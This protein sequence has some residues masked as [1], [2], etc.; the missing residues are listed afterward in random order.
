M[1][2]YRI[3]DSGS[4]VRDIQDRLAALGFDPETDP[5]GWFGEATLS[6]VVAFQKTRG[7]DPD[8][9]V[10]PD[11]WR[12]LYEAGF[13]IGDRLLF[14]RRPM[15]R[16]EDIAELQSRLNSLGF[17]CG[18]VDGIFGPLSE[19]AVIDFQKNRC[20]AEDGKVGPDVV[21]EIQLVTR[22]ARN[23]GRQAIREREWLKRLPSTLA[24]AR[25]YL[26]AGCR[27]PDEACRTWEAA[28]A[29]AQAV[30]EAG[31]IPVM[32]R[33][34]DSLIPERV[35]ALRA[36]RLGSDVIIAFRTV[37]ED[38]E[39]SVF[40]F[41]SELSQSGAGEELA[42]AIAASVGSHVEGRASVLLKETRAPAAV[43]SHRVLDEKLGRS[44]A[45]GLEDFFKAM[46]TIV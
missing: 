45:D 31:G 29:T 36:N 17:D 28:S 3:G 42:R 12:S 21:T 43:V 38:S 18:K 7:I 22:G 5:R 41:A 32:S 11:T 10:G 40:Y 4:P 16:G 30:Q 2:L 44:V 33:S 13:R 19:R 24:G 1:R 25:I 35:R 14:L 27:D 20:L 39:D 37:G 23:Q 15:M 34:E 9:V 8:G 26:D 46:S 6:A